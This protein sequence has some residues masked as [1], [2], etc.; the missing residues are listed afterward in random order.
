MYSLVVFAV[1]FSAA[2]LAQTVTG[3]LEGR[4]SDPAG[5]TVPNAAIRA[6]ESSTGALRSTQSN[7]EGYYQLP[8]LALGAYDVTI[9]SPGFQGQSGR[10][11][12]AL[13]RATVLNF[14]LKV[15]GVQESVTEIGRASCRE[16]V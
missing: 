7:A 3:T 8:F 4:V 2:A 1:L 15:A 10:A 14:Q 16:R 13:N 5:A 11:E 9:E 12:I 6:K